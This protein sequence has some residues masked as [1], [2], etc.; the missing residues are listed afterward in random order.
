MDKKLLYFI[1]ILGFAVGCW[2]LAD[3]FSAGD[4]HTNYGSFVVWGLWVSL[5]FLFGG[6]ATGCFVWASLDLIFHLP[7]FSGTGRPAL[8]AAL[9]TLVAGL[10]A[11]ALDLGHMDR[12]W[13]TIFQ[14]NM[15]SGV[16]MDVWGY[17]VFGLVTVV[18]LIVSATQPNKPTLQ[19]I[20]WIGLIV[21][22]VV[23]G[24]PGKLLGNNAA[25]LFWHSSLMPLQYLLQSL[26]A[27]GAMLLVLRG[28]FPKDLPGG[29]QPGPL[30]KITSLLVLINLFASYAFLTQ[31]L[32]GNMPEIAQPAQQILFGQFSTSFWGLQIIVG[33]LIPLLILFTCRGR[34]GSFLIGLAGLFIL[35][36]NAVERYLVLVTGQ[37]VDLLEGLSSSFTGKGLTLIYSPSMTEWAVACGLFG[38]VILGLRTGFD[39]FLPL[40]HSPKE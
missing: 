19:I 32:S 29:Y 10:A 20:M 30:E 2:G 22:V 13:K 28:L 25:R 26:M 14:T 38:L 6:I 35:L 12:F 40:A 24:L 37:Q 23:S 33:S 8:L 9:V 7:S 21:S 1:G 16:A 18:A 39:R 11:I 36:G 3:F 31:S 4:A 27:G 5:Y 15:S 34:A 17:T